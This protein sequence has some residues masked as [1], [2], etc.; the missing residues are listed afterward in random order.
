[1]RENLLILI[2]LPPHVVE[3]CDGIPFEL[4]LLTTSFNNEQQLLR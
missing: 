2:S 3:L 1:M 4:G